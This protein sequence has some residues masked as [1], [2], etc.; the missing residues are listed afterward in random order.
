MLKST[1]IV[2]NLDQ[3]GR[4]V[5]PIELRRVLDIESGDDSVEVFIDGSTIIFKKYEPGCVFCGNAGDIFYFKGR[6]V[7]QNCLDEFN[8]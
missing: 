7:C 5:L 2:R 3:L 6:N 8:K 1:G 4:I